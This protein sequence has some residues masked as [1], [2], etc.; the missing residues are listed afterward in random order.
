MCQCTT[1]IYS[2]CDHYTL[3]ADPCPEAAQGRLR[4][5]PTQGVNVVE[6]MVC[7][8]CQ[9]K[10]DKRKRRLSSR[11]AAKVKSMVDEVKEEVT[12]AGVK[13]ISRAPAPKKW[14]DK[15]TATK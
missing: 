14:G 7:L 15:F 9:Q 11:I 2:Q 4:C 3:V 13:E 12:K 5:I 8:E 1:E 10:L 6:D